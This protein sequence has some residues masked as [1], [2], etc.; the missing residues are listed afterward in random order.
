MPG[1][2]KPNQLCRIVNPHREPII[3]Q[4]VN[5]VILTTHK[6]EG[7]T[8][9]HGDPIWYY[10][11]PHLEVTFYTPTFFGYIAEEGTL[12]ALPE[13]MLEPIEDGE[14]NQAD[15]DLLKIPDP[16]TSPKETA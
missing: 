1:R 8:C 6:M 4:H 10:V 2:I 5:K 9:D 13:C 3:E 7:E 14:P 15:M 12:A 11:P 16:V